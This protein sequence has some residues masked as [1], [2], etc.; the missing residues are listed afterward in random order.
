MV[1]PQ[2][3]ILTGALR[4]LHVTPATLQIGGTREVD[5]HRLVFIC[6]MIKMIIGLVGNRIN[7]GIVSRYL[8]IQYG[9]YYANLDTHD[10]LDRL[11]VMD[12]LMTLHNSYPNLSRPLLIWVKN[13][14]EIDQVYSRN[15]RILTTKDGPCV[16]N[17]D[18][19][20]TNQRIC[21]CSE[22][23][24]IICDQVDD[25]MKDFNLYPEFL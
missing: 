23:W 21:P 8:R 7:I 19:Q 25:V 14:D 11:D 3:S 10:D 6:N 5:G 15:G 17:L 18:I 13:I 12:K 16:I 4:N 22:K 9:F 20:E 24:E 2:E 1:L